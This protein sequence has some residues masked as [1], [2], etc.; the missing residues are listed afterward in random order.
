MSSGPL[1]SSSDMVYTIELSHRW[2]LSK[3]IVDVVL[4]LAGLGL[5][6]PLIA[7]MVV[8]V[9]LDSRGN[10]FFVR[11]RVGKDG[12]IFRLYKMRTFK[13][14]YFGVVPDE[15][16]GTEDARLTRVGR[17]LR[18]TKLDEL[19]Q[20]WNV[21]LGDMSLVGPRPDIPI[22]VEKYTPRQRKRLAVKPGLTGVAQ[23]SGNTFLSWPDRIELDLWYIRHGSLWLDLR[24]LFLTPWAIL[25]G[26]RQRRDPLKIAGQVGTRVQ[27][28]EHC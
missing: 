19:P 28:P 11:E 21:V 22:Q 17:L 23:I 14:E 15:E 13:R 8:L 5:T 20:L 16:I 4:S 25:A 9:R 1:T 10:P 18:R 27:G 12:C 7:M 2:M 6:S 26:E 3:R 24:I